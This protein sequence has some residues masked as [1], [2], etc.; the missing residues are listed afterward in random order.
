MNCRNIVGLNFFE[1]LNARSPSFPV[2]R[3]AGVAFWVF[4]RLR[5]AADATAF[6]NVA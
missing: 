4:F 2:S 1:R 6:A 5:K 3:A